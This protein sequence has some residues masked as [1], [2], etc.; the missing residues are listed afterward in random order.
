MVAR[1]FSVYVADAS[2]RTRA[3]TLPQYSTCDVVGIR[4][5]AEFQLT[6]TY[7]SIVLAPLRHLLFEYIKE[8]AC[9]E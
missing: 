1:G 7:A 9:K 3:R 6:M 8:E 2:Y 5:M 4:R